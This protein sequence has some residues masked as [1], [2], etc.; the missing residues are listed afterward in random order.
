MAGAYTDPK[1]RGS[2]KFRIPKHCRFIGISG[3]VRARGNTGVSG[4]AVH[5]PTEDQY[6]CARE[7]QFN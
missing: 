4:D 7:S 1:N 3:A 6:A 5:P 2:L